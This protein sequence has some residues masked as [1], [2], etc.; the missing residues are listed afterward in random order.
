MTAHIAS[1]ETFVVRYPVQGHFRF[2]ET[3]RG[4]TPMRDTVVVKIVA[5]SGQVGWGQSVPSH[6]WS[7]ETVET[8]QT[9]IDHYLAP[10]LVGQDACDIDSLWRIMNR[11]IA[12]SF[13]TGQPICKAGI[14]LALFD[15]TGRLLNQT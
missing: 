15:L 14:D 10:A 2:F 4:T 8:V 3:A 11:M 1:V 7:Y 13:S 6:T 9:T 5:D 12:G